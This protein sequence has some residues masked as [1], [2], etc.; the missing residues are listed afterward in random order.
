MRHQRSLPVDA[1]Q[2]QSPS[3]S[4]GHGQAQRPSPCLPPKSPTW[5]AIKPLEVPDTG[6]HASCPCLPPAGTV[7]GGRM[8]G[9]RVL[10][11]TRAAA[12][13]AAQ[14]RKG[15]SEGKAVLQLGCEALHAVPHGRP[16]PRVWRHAPWPQGWSVAG[17]WHASRRSHAGG[18]PHG[19]AWSGRAHHM[20]WRHAWSWAHH[21]WGRGAAHHA[22]PWGTH[23]ARHARAR[24]HHAR[25]WRKHPR[26]LRPHGPRW[27]G[28]HH[29]AHHPRP[30]L[31]FQY[32]ALY[33]ALSLRLLKLEVI[34]LNIR[35]VLITRVVLLADD[36]RVMRQVRVAIITV[37]ARHGAASH[38]SSSHC[39]PVFLK[40]C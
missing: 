26:L 14:P 17:G 38:Q 32:P 25:A 10:A 28:P 3:S 18:R 13:L 5:L 37:K 15:G 30:L 9:T 20:Q 24:R 6:S 12:P 2:P 39:W 22:W 31:V 35:L 7:A 34:G 29:A 4:L 8:A 16:H 11:L 23:H 1:S 19:H 21:A 33:L 27:R 36:G 40:H